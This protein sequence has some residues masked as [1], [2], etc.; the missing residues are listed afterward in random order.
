MQFHTIVAAFYLDPGS[1]M[2]SLKTL[3]ERAGMRDVEPVIHVVAL[4]FLEPDRVVLGG[5]WGVFGDTWAV[6]DSVCGLRCLQLYSSYNSYLRRVAAD[7]DSAA[8]FVSEFGRS[9]ERLLARVALLDTPPHYEDA[10]WVDQLGNRDWVL[11]QA[12]RVATNEIGALANERVSVLYLDEPMMQRWPANGSRE[13]RDITDLPH[14]R[15]IFPGRGS[16][17]MA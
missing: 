10:Q 9:C 2:G 12:A 8:P 13:D 7:D 16:R 4:G 11:E 5:Q 3:A 6:L 17:R 14:G 1:D 15:L